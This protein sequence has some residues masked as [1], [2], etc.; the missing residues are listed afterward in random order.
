MSKRKV[1][2]EIYAVNLY[3]KNKENQHG[4]AAMFDVSLASLQQRIRNY[5]SMGSMHS[6]KEMRNIQKIKA[7]SS[8]RLFSRS[9]FSR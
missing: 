9:S 7:T 3:L 4:I 2:V 5:E 1:S 8:F 6:Q